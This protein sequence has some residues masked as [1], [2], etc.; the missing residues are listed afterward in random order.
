MDVLKKIL[1]GVV[2][3][4]AVTIGAIGG[5]VLGNSRGLKRGVS[6]GRAEMKDATSY[7]LMDRANLA[8]MGAITFKDKGIKDEYIL[9]LR[10]ASGLLDSKSSEEVFAPYEN[11]VLKQRKSFPEK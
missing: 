6:Q 2:V 4:N 3:L 1:M 11:S 8:R 10:Y 5:S 7:F 9:H